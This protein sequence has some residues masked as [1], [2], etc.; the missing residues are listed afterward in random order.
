MTC[1][2][3]EPIVLSTQRATPNFRLTGG[4][5]DRVSSSPVRSQRKSVLTSLVVHEKAIPFSTFLAQSHVNDKRLAQI[6]NFIFSR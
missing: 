4:G 6:K 2:F 1:T 5:G 3:S